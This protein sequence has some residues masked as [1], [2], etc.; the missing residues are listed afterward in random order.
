MDPGEI[1]ILRRWINEGANWPDGIDLVLKDKSDHWAFKPLRVVEPGAKGNEID[2]FIDA[3]LHELGLQRSPAADSVSWLRRG[4]V[5]SH[6]TTPT[7]TEVESFL[8][9]RDYALVVERLLASPRY[10]ERWGQHW[11][12]VV[13]Y[14]DTH[15]FEVNTERPKCLALSRLCDSGIQ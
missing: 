9:K 14:A 5:G 15:G 12:D 2:T 11:L 8:R 4:H 3:K 7:P 10:G 6:R 1:E 13:R